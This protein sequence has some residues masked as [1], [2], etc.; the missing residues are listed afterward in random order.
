MKKMQK[1]L[2]KKR[3]FKKNTWKLKTKKSDLD[4]INH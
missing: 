4:L 3:K 2:P 1:K